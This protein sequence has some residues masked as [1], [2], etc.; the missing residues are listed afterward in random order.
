M[1][2]KIR[3]GVFACLL[4]ASASLYAGGAGEKP[5]GR[6]LVTV[7]ILP[8][9]YFV[10]RISA[11]RVDVSVLVGPGQSPHSYEPTPRQM[12]DLA[13]SG[14]WIRSNTDFE[15]S[16]EPKVRSQMPRLLIVDGT[17]GVAFRKLEA[18]KHDEDHDEHGHDEH[19][20]DDEDHDEAGHDDGHDSNIDRH[21]WLGRDSAKIFAAHVRDTLVAVDPAGRETYV[22][23]ERALVAEID[24]TFDSLAKRLLPLKGR[25][26]FVFHPAFGYFLDEFGLRQEAVEVGGKEPTAKALSALIAKAREEKAR[27]IFVQAQFP[28]A[29]A[30]Q[31]ADSVGA[32]VVPLD[33]LD[34]DWMGNITKM[35]AALAGQ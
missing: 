33:P 5:S 15:E 26:V 30:K 1:I 12:S 31:V 24:A 18:H 6:P 3:I 13:R 27:A 2:N 23:N 7:S 8:H 21:T 10:E 16:L 11:G 29:A 22:A 20:H 28:V 32:K 14:A 19:G 9:R 4:L 35:G 34:P 17:A 25:S